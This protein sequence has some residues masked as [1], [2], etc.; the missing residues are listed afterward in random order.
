MYGDCDSLVDIDVMLTQLPCHTVAKR[1]RGYEHLDILWGK[2]VDRDVIPQIFET[3]GH[4][5]GTRNSETHPT[6]VN[7]SE[8]SNGLCSKADP[9]FATYL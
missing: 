8:G 1:L 2:D 7:P 4:Y 5:C 3:L 9:A 6:S